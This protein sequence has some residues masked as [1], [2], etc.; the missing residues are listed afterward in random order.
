MIRW[1][2][3]ESLVISLPNC[4]SAD[5]SEKIPVRKGIAYLDFMLYNINNLGI[6]GSISQIYIRI[7]G[8]AD[9]IF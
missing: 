7:E 3:Q 9:D 1:C 4:A 6:M 2:E 8:V 5:L